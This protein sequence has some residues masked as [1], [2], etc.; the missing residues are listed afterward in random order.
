VSDTCHSVH[1]WSDAKCIRQA[2]HD[3]LCWNKATTYK[4]VTTRIEWYSK[5]GKFHTHHQYN[6]KYFT[7]TAKGA[8]A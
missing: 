3:G 7:N 6:S 2:G 5:G 1:K 4:G 8:G